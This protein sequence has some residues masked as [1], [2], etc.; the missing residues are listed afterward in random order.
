MREPPPSHSSRMYSLWYIRWSVVIGNIAMSRLQLNRLL[1]LRLVELRRL[2]IGLA[3]EEGVGVES[4]S[5]QQ[6]SN[7]VSVRQ[8]CR[9]YRGIDMT[10]S[11]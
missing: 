4:S 8:E 3:H 7:D 1:R 6:V 5:L 9:E 2:H 11:G 10:Y